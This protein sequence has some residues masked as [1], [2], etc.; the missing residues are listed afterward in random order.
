MNVIQVKIKSKRSTVYLTHQFLPSLLELEKKGLVVLTQGKIP[1]EQASCCM[2]LE[3][4]IKV[5]NGKKVQVLVPAFEE[6]SWSERASLPTLAPSDPN[7]KTELQAYIR[8]RYLQGDH[9]SVK[10]ISGIFPFLSMRAVAQHL[11][12]VGRK[13]RDEGK[14]LLV[15]SGSD[16]YL[17]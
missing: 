14:G 2:T 10:E 17:S 7:F 12:I 11:S 13:L 9:L 15:R 8:R 3:N 4:L 6:Q 5:L 16:Y 1:K